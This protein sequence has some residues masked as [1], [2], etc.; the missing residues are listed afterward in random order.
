MRPHDDAIRR[1]ILIGESDKYHH[2]D[3]EHRIDAFLREL[4]ELITEGVVFADPVQE[5][6][7]V[8]RG[9]SPEIP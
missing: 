9:A 1:T 8:G 4:D 6:R 7:Y 5:Y 2:L 3:T